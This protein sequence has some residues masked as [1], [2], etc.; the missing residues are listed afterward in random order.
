MPA[1]V[2]KVPISEKRGI[3]HA[4]RVLKKYFEERGE[5][6]SL[7]RIKDPTGSS[8]YAALRNSQKLC[9]GESDLSPWYLSQFQGFWIIFS[10]R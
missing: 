8:D 9:V 7:Y 10:G 6:Y 2:L 1:G 3:Y 5:M 4:K